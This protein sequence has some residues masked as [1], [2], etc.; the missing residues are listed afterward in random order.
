LFK[1][2]HFWCKKGIGRV[3]LRPY[4]KLVDSWK[5]RQG[6][7]GLPPPS[8]APIFRLERE[9]PRLAPGARTFSTTQRIVP[10]PERAPRVGQTFSLTENWCTIQ[11]IHR[12]WTNS[13]CLIVVKHTKSR[14]TRSQIRTTFVLSLPVG[15]A[16]V[17]PAP[18]E[19]V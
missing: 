10:P 4:I 12:T 18:A 6:R 5:L 14:P 8:C 16:L 15:R 9:F 13:S 7:A 11:L 3:F 1:N 17:L 2:V 19:F